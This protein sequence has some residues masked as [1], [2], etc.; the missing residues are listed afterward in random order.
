M[1]YFLFLISGGDGVSKIINE[2]VVTTKLIYAKNL[3]IPIASIC[4]SETLLG[5][6][7]ILDDQS[8]HVC[9]VH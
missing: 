5:K 6:A 7:G 9:Q 2:E 1:N 8:L 4:D 3:G